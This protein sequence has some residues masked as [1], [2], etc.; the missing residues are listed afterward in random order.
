MQ[1]GKSIDTDDGNCTLHAKAPKIITS[2]LTSSR[3][4]VELLLLYD[5]HGAAFN[6]VHLSAF[7]NMMGKHARR[8]AAGGNLNRLP[9]RHPARAHT[10]GVIR[11]TSEREL[12]AIAWGAAA[13]GLDT[14][15]WPNLWPRVADRAVDELSRQHAG[16]AGAAWTTKGLATL[17]WA[18]ATAGHSSP[19]LYD[20]IGRAS[21]P[22]LAEFNQHE[23]SNIVWAFATAGHPDEAL[24]ST[25]AR[26]VAARADEFRPQGLANTAC[27]LARA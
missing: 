13:A 20:A 27:N 6:R 3:S 2:L 19:R 21:V 16:H 18:F 8:E 26:E 24:F 5:E 15:K 9:S 14:H 7:W 12:S 17:A 10:L 22:R 4:T 23:C 11:D 25:A 1:S